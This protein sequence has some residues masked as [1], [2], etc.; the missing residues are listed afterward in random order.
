MERLDWLGDRV[1]IG[2]CWTGLLYIL[3]WHLT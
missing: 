3:Y 2:M 1:C